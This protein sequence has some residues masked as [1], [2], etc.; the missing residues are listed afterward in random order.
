MFVAQASAGAGSGQPTETEPDSNEGKRQ[1]TREAGPIRVETVPGAPYKV[2]IVQPD[3]ASPG[4][5]MTWCLSPEFLQRL[6]EELIFNPFLLIL[7]KRD[8]FDI[9]QKLVPLKQG[10][11]RLE[12][13]ES[14]EFTIYT[15]IVRADVEHDRAGQFSA[16]EYIEPIIKSGSSFLGYGRPDIKKIGKSGY[17]LGCVAFPV[18]SDFDEYKVNI[19]QE[20]FAP[21]PPAWLSWWVNLW[22]E[23]KQKNECHFRRR[24]ITAF[25]IQPPMILLWILLRAV[26]G[27]VFALTLALIGWRWISLVPILRPFALDLKNINAN[28]ASHSIGMAEGYWT[29]GRKSGEQFKKFP[30]LLRIL[31]MPILWVSV[32]LISYFLV[33]RFHEVGIVI[34]MTICF[35]VLAVILTGVAA[36]IVR[37][38]KDWLENTAYERYQLQNAREAEQILLKK[39]RSQDKIKRKFVELVCGVGGPSDGYL[40]SLPPR[41]QTILVRFLALKGRVCRPYAKG[42]NN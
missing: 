41:H 35:V 27:V 20:F 33:Y 11:T 22:F 2:N 13:Y 24:M 25:T 12:F 26:C 1:E 32:G 39:Q 28:W 19:D 37:M 36:F 10:G 23:S 16:F 17:N 42:Y 14:G 21:A 18:V 9:E 6:G 40:T 5:E 38:V 31:L 3:K 30:V 8:G 29:I 7:V 4:L 15:T 34:A